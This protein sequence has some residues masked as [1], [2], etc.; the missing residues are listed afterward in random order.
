[1]DTQIATFKRNETRILCQ[2]PMAPGC[3]SFALHVKNGFNSFKIKLHEHIHSLE[4]M[5]SQDKDTPKKLYAKV[6]SSSSILRCRLCNCVALPKH[7]KGLFR[8][9]NQDILRSAEVFYGANL[10]QQT[11]LPDQICAACERRLNNA[12]EFQN[13]I[14][15]TQHTLHENTR[16]KRCVELSSSINSSPK[17]RAVGTLHRRSIDF[18]VASTSQVEN[19]NPVRITDMFFFSF[20]YSFFFSMLA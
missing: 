9:Q 3:N 10:P 11:E 12:V 19:V 17:V 1:M 16:S 4:S 8:T 20:C 15:E 5:A 6:K 2:F 14:A 13:V 18:N 7:S